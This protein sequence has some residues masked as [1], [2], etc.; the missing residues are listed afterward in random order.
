MRI[1]YIHQYFTTRE[2]TLGTRSYEFAK[3]LVASG[4]EVTMLTTDA[5][6]PPLAWEREGSVFRHA[7]I[8]G[9]KLIAVRVAYSNYM[10]FIRRITAFLAFVC[11]ASLIVLTRPGIELI[12]ATSTPLTVAIPAL[13][14]KM[15]RRIPYVFEVRDLWPEAPIQIGAI[16]HPLFIWLLRK[17]EMHTYRHARHLVALSPGMAAGIEATGIA[18]EKITMI[19]NCADL[20]L[21]D[22]RQIDSTVLQQM[23]EQFQLAGKLVVLHGGS[24]GLA[25]G[26]HAVVE[27][28]IQLAQAGEER[29][30][31]LFAGEGR[32]RPELEALAKR[33]GLTN[34]LFTGAL[35]RKEMPLYLA[36]SDITITSFL[37]LPILATNS[38]NKFFDS[39]AAA[40]PVIVN[41]AG[42]TKELVENY[43]IGYYVD[44]K[45]PAELAELL[46]SLIGKK[47]QL[48]RMGERARALAQ[49]EYE[50]GK[51]AQQLEA[52]LHKAMNNSSQAAIEGRR[53]ANES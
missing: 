49:A 50:R 10:G 52:V 51:L 5:Y 34:V 16:R 39:L 23:V 47:E 48:Q 18:A 45:R 32:M 42:W 40:K 4:H 12:L 41:S 8:D 29:I 15:L 53:Y 44:P 22:E 46:L 2:G 37:P 43:Q 25:N 11:Y 20:D 6:L 31:F 7:T 35:P 27:A 38:P 26:L 14:A 21:F 19:P 24:L 33:E 3:H 30:V 13:L 36:V 17:L 28:A 9:I 1:V